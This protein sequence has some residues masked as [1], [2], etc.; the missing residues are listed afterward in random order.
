MGSL[1]LAM[2]CDVCR[3]EFI[4]LANSLISSLIAPLMCAFY[5]F[6]SCIFITRRE[7]VQISQLNQMGLKPTIIRSQLIPYYGNKQILNK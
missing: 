1:H 3:I 7:V 5:V 6:I 2:G 4:D